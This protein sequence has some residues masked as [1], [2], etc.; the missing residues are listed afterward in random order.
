MRLCKEHH[1]MLH[2]AITDHGLER[3]VPTE[4]AQAEERLRSRLERGLLATNFEPVTDITLEIASQA[5]RITMAL[6]TEDNESDHCI[7]PLCYLNRCHKQACGDPDCEFNY[8]HWIEVA[9]SLSVERAVSL[10]LVGQ[11]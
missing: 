4:P 10:G 3:F 8:D 5:M 9:A 6:A 1:H 11:A 2:A 7:C